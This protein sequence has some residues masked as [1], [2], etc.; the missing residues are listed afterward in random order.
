MSPTLHSDRFGAYGCT[1]DAQGLTRS[2]TQAFC[3]PYGATP[4]QASDSVDERFTRL[5]APCK[6]HARSP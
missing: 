4:Q 2:R 1:E 3:A 6:S 5:A